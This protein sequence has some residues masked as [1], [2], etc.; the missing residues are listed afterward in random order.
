MDDVPEKR[1][2]RRFSPEVSDSRKNSGGA[3]SSG[4]ILEHLESEIS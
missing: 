3:P 4:Q 2:K 1:K